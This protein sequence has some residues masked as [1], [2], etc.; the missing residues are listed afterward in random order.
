M[1]EMISGGKV[2]SMLMRWVG[3][4]SSRSRNGEGRGKKARRVTH[5][6]CCVW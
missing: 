2:C 5:A 3:R 1:F 4:M 6:Q